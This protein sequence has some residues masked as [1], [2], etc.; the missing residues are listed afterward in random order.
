MP[1]PGAARRKRLPALLKDCARLLAPAQASLILTI[2]AIRASSLAFDQ[3]CREVLAGRDGTFS[4]GEL[5]IREADGE[6]LLPAS[7]FTR[8]SSG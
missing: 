8:W 1:D 2:Y 5:A 4:S 7:L 6:R 3:L